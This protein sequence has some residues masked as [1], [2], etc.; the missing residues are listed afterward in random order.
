MLTVSR[1][2]ISQAGVL[3]ERYHKS[4]YSYLARINRDQTIAK[5]LTQNVFEKMIK[6]RGSYD[7]RNNFKAWLFSIARNVNID[8]HRK[9]SHLGLPEGVEKIDD[10]DS[11]HEVMEKDE[12]HHKLMRA[13]DLLP[14]EE[15]EIIVLTKFE[16]MK[17]QEVSKL[18]GMTETALK[19]KAHRTIKKLRSILINDLKYEY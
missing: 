13:L 11:V 8:Q 7:D 2:D 16:K 12:R 5:D 18:T 14:A 1:G 19:V 3:F 4:V 17:Y 6:Y 15:K 9:R 10:S